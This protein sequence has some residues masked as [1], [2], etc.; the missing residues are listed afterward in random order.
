MGKKQTRSEARERAFSLI[1]QIGTDAEN[2]EFAIEQMLEEYPESVDNLQ[3]IKDAVYGVGERYEELTREISAHLPKNR[4]ITR[5]SKTV[6]AILLLAVY[7]MK[8]IDDVPGKVAINEAVELA[9]KYSEEDAAGFVN[10]VLGA[11][12]EQ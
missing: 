9:K 5:L 12:I 3:Y 2:T 6:T 10:G 1:F 4:A 11:V 7:E 8:Y